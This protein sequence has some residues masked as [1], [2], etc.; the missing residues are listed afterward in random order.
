MAKGAVK[1]GL[2]LQPLV[3]SSISCRLILSPWFNLVPVWFYRPDFANRPWPISASGF[4]FRLEGSLF[5]RCRRWRDCVPFVNCQKRQV[6]AEF[7]CR[8]ASVRNEDAEAESATLMGR[9]MLSRERATCP[10]T[11]TFERH[12][13]I[14][15]KLFKR[16]V[17][18]RTN[19]YL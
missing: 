9:Y 8:E 10:A 18:C 11:P 13:R 3:L 2:P 1:G 17:T 19:G 15:L 6:D 12:L 4:L 14:R 16:L 5:F 7:Q